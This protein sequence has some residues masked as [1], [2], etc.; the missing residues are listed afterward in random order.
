MFL[1]WNYF[2]SFLLFSSPR[3]RLFP[4]KDLPFQ[5]CSHSLPWVRSKDNGLGSAPTR[6]CDRSAHGSQSTFQDSYPISCSTKKAVLEPRRLMNAACQISIQEHTH[7][8]THCS[9]KTPKPFWFKCSLNPIC[10]EHPSAIQGSW[11]LLGLLFD[12]QNPE[13]RDLWEV[14]HGAVAIVWTQSHRSD[15]ESWLCRLVQEL[16]AW[17]TLWDLIHKSAHVRSNC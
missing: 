12:Q 9:T 5:V 2:P 8:S 1:G 16:R 4:A 17:L 13:K 15:F 10:E 3:R 7:I 6:K 11:L 14:S